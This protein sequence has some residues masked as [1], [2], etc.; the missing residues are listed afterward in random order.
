MI[1]L[2]QRVFKRDPS[3][4]TAPWTVNLPMQRNELAMFEYACH[5]GNYSMEAMLAGARAD[6]R[7]A[8][9][10]GP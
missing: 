5:E 7:A 10:G 2:T 3:T 1:E 6:D 4:W 9:E 8:A